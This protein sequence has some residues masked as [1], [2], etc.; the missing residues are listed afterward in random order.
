MWFFFG[1]FKGFNWV[2]LWFFFLLFKSCIVVCFLE[3]FWVIRWLLLKKI[4]VLVDLVFNFFKINFI[5]GWLFI[6][7]FK[8]S[9]IGLFIGY[10]WLD[11]INGC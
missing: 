6:E 3:I 8:I 9:F 5:L 7:V 4:F 11:L 1:F 2:I 10:G